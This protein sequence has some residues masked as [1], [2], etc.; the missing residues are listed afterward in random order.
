MFIVGWLNIIYFGSI[1]IVKRS[2]AISIPKKYSGEVTLSPEGG[3]RLS[4]KPIA[5]ARNVSIREGA[6]EDIISFSTNTSYI[7]ATVKVK[8]KT[9]NKTFV[10]MIVYLNKVDG[11]IVGGTRITNKSDIVNSEYILTLDS[12]DEGNYTLKIL[13]NSHMIIEYIA[14]RGLCYEVLSNPSI[15]IVFS[16]EEFYHHTLYYIERIDFRGLWISILFITTGLITITIA[17]LAYITMRI[18]ITL[19]HTEISK[20]KKR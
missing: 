18:P 9:V 12:L 1:D 8:G 2:Y 15:S 3:Q 16:P 19:S 7:W 6:Q 10:D 13:S 5:E 20:I 11:T 17:L 4:L 14:V